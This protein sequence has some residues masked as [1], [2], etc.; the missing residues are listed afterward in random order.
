MASEIRKENHKV[1]EKIEFYFP[2]SFTELY[3]IFCIHYI[4]YIV[5]VY[6]KKCVF[7]IHCIVKIVYTLVVQCDFKV[8]NVMI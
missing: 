6:T 4:Y 5:I 7:C 2:P 8:Y 1:K 3:C